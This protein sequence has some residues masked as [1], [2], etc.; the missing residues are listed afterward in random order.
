M[1]RLRKARVA[2]AKA[3]VRRQK[4]VEAVVEEEM[5]I[6]LI[7]KSIWM[8]TVVSVRMRRITCVRWNIMENS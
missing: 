1:G 2:R 5:M 7:V 8:N 6:K 3:T 4:G